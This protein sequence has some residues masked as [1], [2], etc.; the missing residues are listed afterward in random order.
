MLPT[1]DERD[2]IMAAKRE[3]ENV[4]LG[5]AEEFLLTLSE[6]THL[7]PRL[8]LW[9]F[10]LDYEATETDI[11]DPLMDLN[12]VIACLANVIIIIALFKIMTQKYS[13]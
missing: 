7:K 6:V 5:K 11:I 1:D 10:K 9:L 3:H 2:K 4:Q 13:M 8:E 12:T